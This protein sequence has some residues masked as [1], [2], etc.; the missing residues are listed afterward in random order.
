MARAFSSWFVSKGLFFIVI[1][2][3]YNLATSPIRAEASTNIVTYVAE[4]NLD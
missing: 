2:N 1:A 3:C 4:Y